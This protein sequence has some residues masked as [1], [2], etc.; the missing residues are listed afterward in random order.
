[1]GDGTRTRDNLLGR[2]GNA[3]RL[4]NKLTVTELA[5]LSNLS[6]SYISQVKHGKC[7]PSQELLDVLVAQ[8]RLK[9]RDYFTLF[10]QSRQAMAVSPRTLEFYRDRLS[11]F[12]RAVDDA[13]ALVRLRLST[14]RK[15][16]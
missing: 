8:T 11:Q 16:F 7:P 1:V 3:L 4:L 9:D 15:M 12:G 14:L 5:Q 13:T 2:Q 6:K 10:L